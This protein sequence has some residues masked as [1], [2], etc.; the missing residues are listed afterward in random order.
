MMQEKN[1]VY[2]C[3]ALWRWRSFSDVFIILMLGSRRIRSVKELWWMQNTQKCGQRAEKR[4]GDKHGAE[5]GNSIS[6][7]RSEYRG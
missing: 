5:E 1:S 4:V 2:A 3:F 6:E 7:S